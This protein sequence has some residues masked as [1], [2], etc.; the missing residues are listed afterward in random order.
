VPVDRR[1][2]DRRI[3][4][5]QSPEG[6]HCPTCSGGYLKLVKDSLHSGTSAHSQ[7]AYNADSADGEDLVLRFS[8]ILECNNDR[9]R[10]KVAVVGT[11]GCE[12]EI[13]EDGRDWSWA[14]YFHPSFTNPPFRF[15][16]VP[17]S[18]PSDVIDQLTLSFA[19]LWASPAAALNHVRTA[20][21]NLLDTLRISRARRI[22]AVRMQSLSLHQR[23]VVLKTRIPSVADALLAIKWMGNAGSHSGQVTRDDVFDAYDILEQVLEELF[24]KNRLAMQ[25]MIREINRRRGPRTKSKKSTAGGSNAKG[26]T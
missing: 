26:N 16:D 1:L 10:E 22:K 11:G 21:E 2:W 19:L 18:A 20:V 9:C 17:D 4:K 8:A 14:E 25:K 7:A 12:R 6:W 23:I 15:I 3:R 24:V 13:Y 5:D